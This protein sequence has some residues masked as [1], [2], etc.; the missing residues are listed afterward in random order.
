MPA[1]AE[2][3]YLYPADEDRPG[4]VIRFPI[5]WD[6]SGFFERYGDRRI[7]TGNMFYVDYA[8]LLTSWEALAWDK[9]CREGFSGDYRSQGRNLER[10][11]AEVEAAL[12]KS[13]WVIVESYEWE[14][15]LS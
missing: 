10:E 4:R 8:F 9:R 6:R 11:M 1:R 14:S 2:R 15:G 5:W 13:R 12:K 7:D 3:I